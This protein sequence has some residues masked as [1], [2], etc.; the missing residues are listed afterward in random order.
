[1]KK[2]VDVGVMADLFVVGRNED[3]R[4]VEGEKY[5]VT[6]EF[7]DGSRMRHVSSFPNMAYVVRETE[8]SDDGEILCEGGPGFDRITD[9][10]FR[11]NRL[12]R[13]VQAAI[14]AGMTI[15]EQHWYDFHAR[16]GSRAYE[17]EVQSMSRRERAGEVE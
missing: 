4:E 6:V 17:I 2:I 13:R 12:C 1:M 8:Y 11:A 5:F 14:A 9:A 10:E 7:A 3:G 16:Y 15:D